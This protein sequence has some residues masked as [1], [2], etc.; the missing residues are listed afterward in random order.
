MMFKT[1]EGIIKPLIYVGIIRDQKLLMVDYVEAPNPEKKGWW[2]PSANLKFGEDPTEIAANTVKA[3]G[4]AP[5]KLK[6]HGVESFVLPGGWHLICHFV[7]EVSG[8][9]NQGPNI[10]AHKWV[11]SDE[12]AA[13]TDVAHGKWEISVGRE[14]LRQG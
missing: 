14:Y 3:L 2:I 9:V 8:D 10:K 11:S 13:M 1:S 7:C 5:D 4:F 12:L 6:L